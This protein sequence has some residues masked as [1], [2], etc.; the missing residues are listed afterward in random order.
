[1][2]RVKYDIFRR[3]I[4]VNLLCGLVALIRARARAVHTVARVRTRHGL[5][6]TLY[7]DHHY[8]S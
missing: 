5:S 6:F 3:R 1:M 8:G 2:Q 4:P 7:V